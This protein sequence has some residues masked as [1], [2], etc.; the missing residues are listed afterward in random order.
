MSLVVL[1]GNVDTVVSAGI[2]TFEDLSIVGPLDAT[3]T[4]G[5]VCFVGKSE[6][7]ALSQTTRIE[8][9][10]VAWRQSLSSYKS[11]STAHL[12][13]PK[14]FIP[15]AL[16]LPYNRLHI[17]VE[18]ITHDGS[19]LHFNS[20]TEFP[21][22]CQMKVMPP[23]VNVTS[24][25]EGFWTF[26]TAMNSQGVVD[27]TGIAQLTPLWI[28]AAFGTTLQLV[29]RCFFDGL[30]NYV[31]STLVHPFQ[32]QNVTRRWLALPTQAIANQKLEIPVEIEIL[33]H[34]F[35]RYRDYTGLV[36]IVCLLS[37]FDGSGG[38]VKVD[39]LGD[40]TA[41]VGADGIAR[42]SDVT[43]VTNTGVQ[44]QLTAQC[45]CGRYVLADSSVTTPEVAAQGSI[46][47]AGGIHDAAS[48]T[49]ALAILYGVNPD[50]IT[51]TFDGGTRRRLESES[52]VTWRFVIMAAREHEEVARIMKQIGKITGD[53]GNYTSQLATHL[54]ISSVELVASNATLFPVHASSMRTVSWDKVKPRWWST[55]PAY[56]DSNDPFDIELEL[57]NEGVT[58]T[59]G[60]VF[61]RVPRGLFDVTCNLTVYRMG[62]SDPELLL[63]NNAGVQKSLFEAWQDN[64][65]TV[66]W[67]ESMPT[68][69]P[70]GIIRFPGLVLVAPMNTTL[71]FH[72]GCY[73]QARAE[74]YNLELNKKN[75]SCKA[76]SMTA[77]A[78][79]SSTT[80]SRPLEV[81]W[82][83]P[84][85]NGT[86]LP[87]PTD[88]FFGAEIRYGALNRTAVQ[89]RLGEHLAVIRT[90]LDDGVNPRGLTNLHPE[91][92]CEID[93]WKIG[94]VWGTA[95]DDTTLQS[96]ALTTKSVNGTAT[97]TQ[98]QLKASIGTQVVLRVRCATEHGLVLP[99]LFSK[100]L[101]VVRNS[102]AEIETLPPFVLPSK[103]GSG[104]VWG[105]RPELPFCLAGGSD[106]ATRCDFPRIRLTSLDPAIDPAT[107]RRA[108][109]LDDYRTM[110]VVNATSTN[111]NGTKHTIM[112]GNRVYVVKGVATFSSLTFNDL[113]LSDTLTL[114]FVCYANGIIHN[115]TTMPLLYGEASA[116][117]LN[118]S[119]N[120]Y[121]SLKSDALPG[122]VSYNVK[123]GEPNVE[124]NKF[125]VQVTDGTGRVM[126]GAKGLV[127]TAETQ[128][129]VQL[130]GG[131]RQSVV[132]GFAYF[133]DLKVEGECVGKKVTI[134]FECEFIYNDLTGF[135]TKLAPVYLD[136]QV[137]N[138]PAG[139]GPRFGSDARVICDET[140]DPPE[141]YASDGCQEH[142]SQCD[143]CGIRDFS[144]TGARCLQ[145][146]AWSQ[147]NVEPA[148]LA[149]TSCECVKGYYAALNKRHESNILCVE[150]PAGSKCDEPGITFE[151]IVPLSG[152][153][154]IVEWF[155]S[156]DDQRFLE[157]LRC[158]E[159]SEGNSHCSGGGQATLGGPVFNNGTNNSLSNCRELHD[160]ILCDSCIKSDD[161]DVYYAK[162]KGVCKRCDNIEEQ[163]DVVAA[164]GVLFLAMAV[165]A[166]LNVG[167]LYML[168]KKLI[169]QLVAMRKRNAMRLRRW[170]Q[171]YS[172]EDNDLDALSFDFLFHKIL[173][174]AKIMIGLAQIVGQFADN[175]PHIRWPPMYLQMCARLSFI[176][177]DLQAIPALVCFTRTSYLE[178]FFF[179]TIFPLFLMGVFG[180]LACFAYVD[181]YTF[182]IKIISTSHITTMA[183]GML[184]L[185]YPTCCNQIFTVLRCQTFFNGDQYLVVDYGVQC[186]SDVKHSLW[187][188]L[189]EM[190]YPEIKAYAGILL[191][192]YPLGVPF[193][194]YSLLHRSMQFLFD[195]ERDEN[196][197]V[198]QV[199]NFETKKTLGFLYAD[200]KPKWF[201]WEVF[202][203]L[204]K[205]FFVGVLLQIEPGTPIQMVIGAI[206]AVLMMLYFSAAWP[207]RDDEDN[208]LQMAS[209][210]AIFV[211]Y[212]MMLMLD[213]DS[214]FEVKERGQ[215]ETVLIAANLLP[216]FMALYYT[217]RITLLPGI[218]LWLRLREVKKE[219]GA[220]LDSK[221][222]QLGHNVFNQNPSWH[223]S[224]S[225]LIRGGAKLPPPF[226]HEIDEKKVDSRGVMT[227]MKNQVSK[228]VMGSSEAD[229]AFYCKV[230]LDGY[231]I[232]ETPVDHSVE[233]EGAHDDYAQVTKHMEPAHVSVHVIK[234]SNLNEPKK[235]EETG[236]V[237]RLERMKQMMSRTNASVLI[238][239]ASDFKF[240]NFIQ[241]HRTKTIASTSPS[242]EQMFEFD[243]S[244]TRAELQKRND[245]SEPIPPLHKLRLIVESDGGRGMLHLREPLATLDVDLGRLLRLHRHHQ[246]PSIREWFPLNGPE[247]QDQENG[248][249]GK[250]LL[251]IEVD[252]WLR[253]HIE[254]ERQAAGT[255]TLNHDK[256]GNFIDTRVGWMHSCTALLAPEVGKDSKMEFVVY[257]VNHEARKKAKEKEKMH[258]KHS[259]MRMQQDRQLHHQKGDTP[260][261]FKVHKVHKDPRAHDHVVGTFTIEEEEIREY[262]KMKVHWT[263][264]AVIQKTTCWLMKDI[265]TNNKK[266][267]KAGVKP[268]QLKHGFLSMDVTVKAMSK[269]VK[270]K[271]EKGQIT[272]ADDAKAI[273]VRCITQT[274]RKS[275]ELLPAY[276]MRFRIQSAEQVNENPV[277]S[278]GKQRSCAPFHRPWVNITHHGHNEI[279]KTKAAKT[280]VNPK[281]NQT[282]PL[283]D[284]PQLRIEVWHKSNGF[285]GREHLIGVTSLNGT[286]FAN[287]KIVSKKTYYQMHTCNSALFRTKHLA[288]GIGLT[289]SEGI[290]KRG[291][292]RIRVKMNSMD[293]IIAKARKQLAL[294]MI[295]TRS[296][297]VEM[298]WETKSSA[299]EEPGN[300]LI[301]KVEDFEKKEGAG[302]D[303]E[304]EETSF[305]QT[306][307]DTMQSIREVTPWSEEQHDTTTNY[308]QGTHINADDNLT[309]H[310]FSVCPDHT[311]STEWGL[312]RIGSCLRVVS[313]FVFPCSTLR[314]LITNSRLSH[315]YR[316]SGASWTATRPLVCGCLRM[317]LGW[318]VSKRLEQRRK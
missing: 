92:I 253:S 235:S 201:F 240:R 124:D 57:L 151:G 276:K 64:N 152:Y 275:I 217:F 132:E 198:V 224:V 83:A 269:T 104:N 202:E 304:E 29:V 268:V 315:S 290:K 207:Y 39:L 131:V 244:F 128:A 238:E 279:A 314:P 98:T 16:V 123:V 297:V 4:L 82:R 149:G 59:G 194:Y 174:K 153:W 168:M 294:D 150:C 278:D 280:A 186:N 24:E 96:P 53:I 208:N 307:S 220:G 86:P 102:V 288:G 213:A 267:Q 310:G 130:N 3:V 284:L 116:L 51:L 286:I 299:T 221:E 197:D 61:R 285:I 261:H 36:P 77:T 46:V 118:T 300:L 81:Q 262:T 35:G 10:Q 126:K 111:F 20:S 144:K 292:E 6:L 147:H 271:L 50:E 135:S 145:C 273:V 303:E 55:P 129:P 97:F 181:E 156:E 19:L 87:L 215:L 18:L 193:F 277:G 233:V 289:I 203:L 127:C 62:D 229:E 176:N 255:H 32:V 49:A 243:V 236:K 120:I 58:D 103:L 291:I 33:N 298:Y 293:G 161:P 27:N 94:H 209:L 109:Q 9:L 125:G 306:I 31:R 76:D 137:A 178:S 248:E 78:L 1:Q 226:K 182:R 231:T 260:E 91:M 163:M 72:A 266:K 239:Y 222:T 89:T 245:G 74:V 8:D 211:T 44:V 270:S 212:F 148:V 119:V 2:A 274:A 136:V 199:I 259:K 133:T 154:Q 165:I 41:H 179:V 107:G 237:S 251:H 196:G 301:G 100:L 84:M 25:E 258:L 73:L 254:A 305:V 80:T 146:P 157:F 247:G 48:V 252:E 219:H 93:L 242:W 22:V 115:L 105:G 141:T 85:H 256:R 257:R 69:L 142:G 68:V 90:G 110:C 63:P 79:I 214:G 88:L 188:G 309:H 99:P 195:K 7:V 45:T 302:D 189:I 183:I 317:L 296:L 225:I 223:R 138:C 134:Q 67:G 52:D 246:R 159:D 190:S 250:I 71:T 204:K 264:P 272:S 47:L 23:H 171:N 206:S 65:E 210:S 187:S 172:L 38:G 283:V 173:T 17:I 139:Y 241:Q 155:K 170:A 21:L 11:L 70:N 66:F 14:G 180:A 166:L 316:K 114:V 287:K 112:G 117:Q 164:V 318:A 230:L 26:D 30:P 218:N 15:P 169:R 140:K 308:V 42:F 311:A 177:I 313:T 28:D 106:A 265:L 122:Q 56:F 281:W 263:K 113:F 185:V 232:S 5:V 143:A 13:T 75:S 312:A 191:F 216:L 95:R 12:S 228:I 34:T 234:A 205:V 200:Y 192:I 282:T 162:E 43:P 108:V 249:Y 160:G 40:T 167:L 295:T 121:P 37:A 227:K 101:T 158:E 184:F 60:T 175:Y 54:N